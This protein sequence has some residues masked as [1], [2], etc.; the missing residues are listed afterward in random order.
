[1]ASIGIIG[2]FQASNET[3]VATSVALRDHDAT[4]VGTDEVR[5]PHELG[6]FH[7]LFIAPG[8]PYVS[9]D[10]ALAAIRY[11]RES[12]VPLIGTCA[13]FQH[14]VIELARNVLGIAGAT[15][16]EYDPLADDLFVTPLSC[17]LVGQVLSVVVDPSSV[18]GRSYGSAL[19]GDGEATERYYCRFGLNPAVEP[20]LAEAGLVVSGRD[21]DREARIMELP[22]HPFFVGTLFVPQASSPDHPLVGA[23]LAA[24]DAREAAARHSL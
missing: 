16:A 2:D 21:H 20:A 3:H 15:H 6:P 18:A 1:M 24:A 14:I 22:D 8:S 9:L 23:F 10:G 4:W 13:G 11:A 17:S 12:S 7:G 19:T 5:S